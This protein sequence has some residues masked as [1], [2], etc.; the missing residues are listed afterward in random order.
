VTEVV[1]IPLGCVFRVERKLQN[2]QAGWGTNISAV[3]EE[4]FLPRAT[5]NDLGDLECRPCRVLA[6]CQ[7]REIL[8]QGFSPGKTFWLISALKG[9]QNF[10]GPLR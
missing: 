5:A 7:E 6:L 9:Q 4:D 8:A 10:G 1:S 3:A 2:Q